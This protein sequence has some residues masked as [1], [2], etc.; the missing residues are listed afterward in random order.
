MWEYKIE[1]IAI[2]HPDGSSGEKNK[3]LS[4]QDKE[5]YGDFWWQK[6]LAAELEKVSKQGWEIVSIPERLLEGDGC[7]GYVLLKRLRKIK[8]NQ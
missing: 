1:Y 7:D 4:K 8:E 5:R 2:F 6:E 3:L